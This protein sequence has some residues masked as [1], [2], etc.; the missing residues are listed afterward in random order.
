MDKSI[1][2]TLSCLDQIGIVA[3]VS[4]FL[5][6]SGCNILDSAQ[7]GDEDTGLFFM[8][9]H[10]RPEKVP[11]SVED[12]R[13]G[14]SPL[15]KRFAISAEFVEENFR[16]RLLVL[17]SKHGHC[18][19]DLLY[20]CGTNALKA[21]IAA[22][23]SN[24]PDYAE[25]V[26]GRGVPFYYLPVT[27]ETRPEQEEKIL[28]IVDKEKIDLL[29]LARYMQVLSADFCERLIGRCINIHHSFLP[30]FKGA[31]PYRQAHAKGVKLIGAT[32]H[33]VT[34]NLDE[35]PIIEQGVDRVDHSYS[36]EEMEALG[37]DLECV[38]LARA[39]RLHI[40]R[41]ILINGH[42]TVILR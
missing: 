25:L 41:R 11:L 34:A 14:F 30:S 21:D 19:N 17:V 24:H 42:K 12:L 10:F 18:L 20:R 29:V 22:V 40:E 28:E 23:I 16:S 15:A 32:A 33:Y 37:R 38:T 39:V 35:G 9:V 1:I 26:K 8:R 5:S 13:N 3:A 2:L 31:K 4:S 7:F 6:D 27:P 36:P